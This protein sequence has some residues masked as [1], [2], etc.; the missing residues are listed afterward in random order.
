LSPRDV[1]PESLCRFDV[2]VLMNVNPEDQLF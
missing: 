1:E 2:G